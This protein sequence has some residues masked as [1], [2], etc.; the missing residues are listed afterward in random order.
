MAFFLRILRKK[1]ILP[2]IIVLVLLMAT[3]VIYVRMKSSPL[4]QVTY[5]SPP[6]IMIQT[7]SSGNYQAINAA[8]GAVISK[9][10]SASSL[11][12]AVI[13]PNLC[14]A[15]QAGT[16]VLSNPIASSDSGVTIEGQGASTII[17]PSSN[18]IDAFDLTGASTWTIENL[19]IT[20]ANYGINC[21]GCSNMAVL[22][23]T[24]TNTDYDA[25]L[26]Q[27]SS[28]CTASGDTVYYCYPNGFAIHLIDTSNSVV[29]GNTADFT[30]WSVIAVSDGSDNVLVTGNVVAAGG[31]EGSE[32]D[33][34]EIGSTPASGGTTGDTVS[35]N[36]CYGNIVDGIS[37]A[38]SS[39]TVIE[40]NNVY[41]NEADGISI[42][43]DSVNTLVESNNV[44]NNSANLSV[45]SAGIIVDD[46]ASQTTIS[47][48]NIYKNWQDGISLYQSTYSTVT[49]NT[50]YDNGQ[51]A[52]DTYDGINVDG[53]NNV[54]E[55]NLLY[56][57]QANPTQQNAIVVNSGVRNNVVTGN[58]ILPIGT[59]PSPTPTSTATTA[60]PPT[61]TAS[62]APTPTSTPT[63]TPTPTP[64]PSPTSTPTPTHHRGRR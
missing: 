48:N 28:N 6:N 14:I 47:S 2:T 31:Q 55:N 4:Y 45:G 49:G 62:P 54:V 21:Y 5:V 18:S 32:G 56:D 11:I 8:T 33:G 7:P 22:G 23:I 41:S 39:G 17:Q 10:T 29:T 42:E 1:L 44:Y 36:T 35:N 24:V 61:S 27:S 63:I 40:N 13:A 37:V 20:T 12:N 46:Q 15:I 59:S 53:S 64:T 30:W 25:I 58:T 19:K 38:Q 9:S 16:Y 26:F 3:I 60:P 43:T 51:A 52:P 57:N 50:I 34:I